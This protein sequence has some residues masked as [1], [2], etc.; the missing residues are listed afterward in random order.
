[1]VNQA[2][3]SSIVEDD[4]Y[5]AGSDLLDPC[6]SCLWLAIHHEADHLSVADQAATEISASSYG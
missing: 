3:G 6:G 4:C 1:M 5:L 2:R